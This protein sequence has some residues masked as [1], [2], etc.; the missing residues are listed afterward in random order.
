MSLRRI[1]LHWSAGGNVPTSL[2]RKHYHF[3]VGGDGQV[4]AGIHP[5]ES[6]IRP[7]RGQYAAHTLKLNTGSIG[8][9]MSGMA[10]AVERPF[11]P[12]R[13]PLTERQVEAFVQLVA[14]LCRQYRIPVT[15]ETVLSHAE[16]WP[17][18]KVRQKGKWDIAW[19]PGMTAPADPVVV[20]DRLRARIQ[21]ALNA[22]PR[23]A[24]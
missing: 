7:V 5:P 16:V 23:E 1:V 20:G 12:G 9:S 17:T 10:G 13:A 22:L 11:N 18:L 6:N 19:L 15:R 14:R 2:E 4:V 3:C 21:A 8:V 24:A